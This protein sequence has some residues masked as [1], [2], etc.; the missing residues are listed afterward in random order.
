MATPKAAAELR[1]TGMFWQAPV[2]KSFKKTFLK[3]HSPAFDLSVLF[4]RPEVNIA[5]EECNGESFN[6]ESYLVGCMDALKTQK[7]I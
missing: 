6:S 4:F 1:E 5:T 7:K 3:V 2:A